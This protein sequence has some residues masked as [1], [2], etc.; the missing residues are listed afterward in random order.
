[1]LRVVN[2][3]A[4]VE[5][6]PILDHVNLYIKEGQTYVLFGPNG[7]GKTSLLMTLIGNPAFKVTY[8]RIMFKG[9]DI[10]DLSTDQR[11]KMGMGISFQ[12]PPKVSG[13]KLID[14]LLNCAKQSGTDQ[15]KI[16]EY[17]QMLNMEKFLNRS[18]NVG[19]SG[20]EVKRSEV[21]QLLI[22]NPDLVLFDEPDS[23]VDLDNIAII[24]SAMGD[25]L[26]R[27]KNKDERKKSGLIITHQG[28]ILDYVD[29]DYGLILYKG[30]I[31]CMGNPYDM[32]DEI[33]KKGYEGCVEKCLKG[34]QNSRRM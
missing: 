3:G 1:M 16:Y 15:N 12:N 5:G 30:M 13:L 25:L 10:N 32:L 9:Q 31:A 33:S 8:G 17:A 19:F 21:L 29:A 11:V 18:V 20:G 24:G 22:L 4:E 27:K 6:N 7:N 28:H 14:M 34:F 23:G 2:L 26:H